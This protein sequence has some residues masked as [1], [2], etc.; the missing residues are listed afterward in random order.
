MKLKIVQRMER[1]SA[2][3]GVSHRYRPRFDYA[4]AA[5][6]DFAPPGRSAQLRHGMRGRSFALAGGGLHKG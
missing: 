5:E 1:K 2:I 4:A 6:A 3:D